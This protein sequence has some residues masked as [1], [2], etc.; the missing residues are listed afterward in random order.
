MQC[1]GRHTAGAAV[2]VVAFREEACA[3]RATYQLLLLLPAEDDALRVEE[4][5]C[6]LRLTYLSME[7]RNSVTGA[8]FEF[9]A[10]A[11]DQHDDHDQH[12]LQNG[13]RHADGD[14]QTLTGATSTLNCSKAPGTPYLPIRKSSQGAVSLTPGTVKHH[15]WILMT[16][17]LINSCKNV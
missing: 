9:V 4:A 17:R 14:K 3:V 2:R 11:A 15:N 10:Q 1:L 6:A 7:F 5:V 16:F 13:H 8:F 12:H